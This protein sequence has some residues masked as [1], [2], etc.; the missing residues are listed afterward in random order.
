MGD[1]QNAGGGTEPSSAGGSQGADDSFAE[2]SEEDRQA[3]NPYEVLDIEEEDDNG[4]MNGEVATERIS[5]RELGKEDAD[6]PDPTIEIPETR[7]TSLVEE[8][9]DPED[10]A[11]ADQEELQGG[12]IG[13][14]GNSYPYEQNS[15]MSAAEPGDSHKQEN[16]TFWLPSQMSEIAAD[17][18]VLHPNNFSADEAIE[19][20]HR[21]DPWLRENRRQQLPGWDPCDIQQQGLVSSSIGIHTATGSGMVLGTVNSA[22]EKMLG[23]PR[24]ALSQKRQD[25]ICRRS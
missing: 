1:R 23:E 20:I 19:W 2:T 17:L 25:T 16:T 24:I 8:I 14:E 22:L 12:N 21:L 5:S 6:P 18:L 15:W 4:K 11:M 7:I 10:E 3:T 9:E 13:G